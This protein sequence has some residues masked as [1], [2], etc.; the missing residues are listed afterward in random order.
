MD[1]TPTEIVCD[2]LSGVYKHVM[3]TLDRRVGSS[4]QPAIITFVLTVPAI[5]SD[6]A[7]TSLQEAALKA[8]MGRSS[9]PR[10]HSEPE[11]AAIHTLKDLDGVSRLQDND[12]ILVC[13]AGG[14]TVD[15]IT[16]DIVQTN[17]LKLI[18]CTA[19]NGDYCG[20][21][22]VDREFEKYLIKRMGSHYKMILP[23][24][25]QQVIKNFE[26]TKA[27][28]RDD[29]EQEVFYVNIPTIGDIEDAGVYSGNLHITRKDMRSLFD[30]V[31]SRI[32]DLIRAQT[33]ELP[34]VDLILLVGGFGESEYL[35]QRIVAW[36]RKFQ[37]RVMQPRE[38]ATSIVRGA[39]L[40]GLETWGHS[41]THITRRARRWYG[42]TINELFVEGRHLQEDRQTNTDTGQVFAKN[43]IRWLIKK[44]SKYPVCPGRSRLTRI[45]N[46]EISDKEYM[47]ELP[48]SEE[49]KSPSEV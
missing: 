20:S 29:P 33:K 14:G 8:G 26:A 17:P 1:L 48:Q 42:V 46:Q 31:V 44:V 32:L 7:R 45:Q 24:Y 47:S 49:R 30:P 38:A 35:Y 39:V 27:A 9:S 19:G 2:Y 15:I 4:G 10:I 22:F 13:D 12:R 25:R 34:S 18:E 5:W 43:Q 28:F 40:K 37:I 11:C 3:S 23:L 36:A 6:A 41:E 16:Y 21:T